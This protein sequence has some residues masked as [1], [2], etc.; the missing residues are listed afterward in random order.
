MTDRHRPLLGYTV[1]DFI[2]GRDPAAGLLFRYGRGVFVPETHEDDTHWDSDGPA[3][4][5]LD[6]GGSEA[7]W[8]RDYRSTSDDV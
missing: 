7:Q 3:A 1:R 6:Q 8:W 5:G 4:E 2:R